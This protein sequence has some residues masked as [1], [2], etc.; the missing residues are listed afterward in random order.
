MISISLSSCSAIFSSREQ[1]IQI[2]CQ[3]KGVN[4]FVDS[5]F[6]LNQ[7]SA[8][9]NIN[10]DL[11]VKQVRL[12]KENYKTLYKVILQ[13]RKS[14]LHFFSW[15]PFILLNGPKFDDGTT[16][17][18]YYNEQ[19]NFGKLRKYLIRDSN[20]KKLNVNIL[21]FAISKKN[22]SENYFYYSDYVERMQPYKTSNI[23]SI[24][25]IDEIYT[26]LLND[27]LINLKFLDSVGSVFSDNVNLLNLY[28]KIEMLNGNKIKRQYT[29]N[30]DCYFRTVEIKTNWKVKNIYGDTLQSLTNSA[31]SGEYS[32]D[33]NTDKIAFQKALED[34]LETTMLDFIDSL[35]VNKLLVKENT[36]LTFDNKINISKPIKTPA[37][38]DE[39]MKA[40]VTIKNK[41]GHGSGFL[42]TNDGYIVTNH[43][44]V[45][46]NTD[47]TVILSD[48][49]EAKATV[50]RSNKSIDLAL[51]KIDGKYEYAFNL[52]QKQNYNVGD[53]I[54][55]I[56][57]PKSIQ[58]GQSVSKGIVSGARKHLG[59]NYLQTDVKINKGNSGGPIV[60]KNGELVSVVE[61]K[62]VGD[63]V[64]G[65]SFSIP[66]YDIFE[67]LNLSY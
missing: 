61:Y 60:L 40:T 3:T 47:Y 24:G 15:I 36:K 20:S 42:I 51:L 11:I 28:A 25:Y 16:K 49:T 19:Y 39:A 34:A 35:N 13:D 18:W 50:V 53:E 66:A 30:K 46:R 65:L 38:I 8:L 52:P 58:L 32:L 62:L 2:T 14:P 54:I 9:F 23:D 27:K 67:N 41:D 63:G 26:N 45:S 59:M 55:A 1:E 10:R 17:T 5:I 31:V 7:D 4:I 37:Q 22:S 56:G 57:T 43:H 6:T 33:L 12:E 21:E 48:G 29:D 44:V 64:E